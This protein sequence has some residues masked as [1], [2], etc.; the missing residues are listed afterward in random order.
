MKQKFIY[1]CEWKKNKETSWSGTNQAV[2]SRLHKD[3]DVIDFDFGLR[4]P[5]ALTAKVIKKLTRKKWMLDLIIPVFL[6]RNSMV[7]MSYFNSG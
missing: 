4:K 3:F 7:G 2:C 5:F 1:S 6:K